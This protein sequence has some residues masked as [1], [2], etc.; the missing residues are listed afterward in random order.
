MLLIQQR[1]QNV[2]IKSCSSNEELRLSF[3][4][5]IHNLEVRND[6]AHSQSNILVLRIKS[7]LGVVVYHL[8]YE[9]RG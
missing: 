1:Q 2:Q 3:M 4:L 7:V 8:H 5:F 9:G 6:T